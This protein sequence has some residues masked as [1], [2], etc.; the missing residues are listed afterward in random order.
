M[1]KRIANKFQNRIFFVVGFFIFI[2]FLAVTFWGDHGIVE[3]LHMKRLQNKIQTQN[4]NILK[5]NLLYLQE[6]ERMQYPQFIEQTAR[7]EL[8]FVR[9]KEIV[10]IVSDK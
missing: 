1:V 2:G 5:E 8:G 3:L 10:Y 7:S 6:I 9:P 4:L